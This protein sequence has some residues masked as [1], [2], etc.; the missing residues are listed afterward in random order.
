VSRVEV[1]YGW[2]HLGLAGWQG[3]ALI[4]SGETDPP[5]ADRELQA[6]NALARY[7]LREPGGV[8]AAATPEAGHEWVPIDQP[9]VPTGVRI[10]DLQWD[11]ARARPVP[12]QGLEITLPRFA[13]SFR[14]GDE[15][16]VASDVFPSAAARRMLSST[17]F[18]GST[19]T[20]SMA[21]RTRRARCS[22]RALPRLTAEHGADFPVTVT[23]TI[24][25]WVTP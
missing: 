8:S 25:D 21:Y 4:A 7:G 12:V 10:R 23:A 9:G 11:R 13:L 17:P 16:D 22:V 1:F 2:D 14:L 24:I 19:G 18:L 6:T 3:H 15:F 5:D 20:T